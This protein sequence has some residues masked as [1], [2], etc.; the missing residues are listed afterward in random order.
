[1]V[2]YPKDWDESKLLDH[3]SLVQGLTYTQ[4]NVK[5]NIFC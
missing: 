3:V 2:T 4:E 5:P 1:M